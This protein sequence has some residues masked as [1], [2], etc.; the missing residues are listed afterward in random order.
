MLGAVAGT[1]PSAVTVDVGL[2]QDPDTGAEQWAVVEANMPWFSHS[3]CAD[4]G[5][6]LD[7]VL[8]AAG[9][10]DLVSSHDLGFVRAAAAPA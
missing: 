4:P 1:L 7:V 8:R 6:V 5:R 10:R 2:A 3:Y 9:P